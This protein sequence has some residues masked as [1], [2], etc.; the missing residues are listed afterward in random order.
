MQLGYMERDGRAVQLRRLPPDRRRRPAARRGARCRRGS[1]MPRL[2]RGN[3]IP[4]PDRGLRPAALRPGRDARPAPPPG[5]RAVAD[6]AR[7]RR[8]GAR[9]AARCSPTT[10][11]GRARSRRRQARRRRAPP[12]RSTARSPASAGPAPPAA[13]R[14]TSPAAL[15]KRLGGWGSARAG[16]ARSTVGP[17][18]CRSPPLGRAAGE[19]P[20]G[21]GELDPP[22]AEAHRHRHQAGGARGARRARRGAAVGSGGPACAGS[23]RARRGRGPAA[24]WPPLMRRALVASSAQLGAAGMRDHRA[25][26]QPERVAGAAGAAAEARRRRR[27]SG[28]RRSR[29][30]PRKTAAGTARLAVAA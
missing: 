26:H 5:L 22:E 21:L 27:R 7:P 6:A 15:A 29:R 10:G 17:S 16:R 23:R 28:R 13:W 3:V 4:L 9:P 8:R 20:G 2:L 30:G 14:T 11:C 24:I 19:Q 18:P 12:G 1:T 25:R